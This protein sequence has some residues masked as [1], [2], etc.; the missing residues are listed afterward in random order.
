MT[1]GAEQQALVVD[2][3]GMAEPAGEAA[4]AVQAGDVEA[5]HQTDGQAMQGAERTAV[6]AEVGIQ[7]LGAGGDGGEVQLAQA[8]GQLVGEGGAVSEGASDLTG[9]VIATAQG[10]QQARGGEGGD[11]LLDGAEEE[12]RASQRCV[13]V[14]FLSLSIALQE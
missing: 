5:I 2:G 4:G 6:L 1:E 7:L 9:R 11:G 10:E 13:H 14:T 12:L 3:L 8:I